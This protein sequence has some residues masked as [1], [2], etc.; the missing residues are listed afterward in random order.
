MQPA[1]N[2]RLGACDHSPPMN[3]VH[4]CR[5][6]LSTTHCER[7][8]PGSEIFR[9]TEAD[10]SVLLPEDLLQQLFQSVCDVRIRLDPPLIQQTVR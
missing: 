3:H 4:P 5:R 10:G 8:Y 7:K 9:R 1:A 2:Q 6:R